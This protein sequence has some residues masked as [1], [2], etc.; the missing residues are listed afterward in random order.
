M[1]HGATWGDELVIDKATW[2]GGPIRCSNATHCVIPG[3]SSN[4]V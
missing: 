3:C 4:K 1:D 2:A